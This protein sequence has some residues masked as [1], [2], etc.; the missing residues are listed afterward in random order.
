MDT[1][2]AYKETISDEQDL[3]ESGWTSY[4][5]DFFSSQNQEQYS[6]DSNNN[7]F[8][9]SDAAS[10]VVDHEKFNKSGQQIPST[11]TMSTK[12]SKKVDM[13]RTST[14]GKILHDDSLD[15]TASSPVNSP[16]IVQEEE[17]AI[18]DLRLDQGSDKKTCEI[19]ME[20][21]K[22]DCTNLRNRLFY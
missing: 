8:L 10:S 1:Y 11:S 16:R 6:G 4:F 7:N 22:N 17:E 15:D 14:N 12:F 13:K 20:G 2:F 19:V 5:D 9:V 21:Q 3:E 18:P